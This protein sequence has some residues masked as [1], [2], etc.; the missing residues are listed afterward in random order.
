MSRSIA[1]CC[2]CST[3][4][5]T[6]PVH[7]RSGS[8]WPPCAEPPRSPSIATGS[9]FVVPARYRDAGGS[10]GA[11]GDGPAIRIRT[12][13][14]TSPSQPF[15]VPHPAITA[16]SLPRQP[17]QRTSSKSASRGSLRNSTSLMSR[18]ASAVGTFSLRRTAPHRSQPLAHVRD[19]SQ[20]ADVQLVSHPLQHVRPHCLK[21][22]SSNA[23]DPLQRT[24]ESEPQQRG[25][26]PSA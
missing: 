23:R 3:T 18:Q 12:A 24:L 19:P 15:H 25:L 8:L 7:Y 4:C 2:Q 16:C 22:C 6:A 20:L 9:A 14:A 26:R 13:L 21:Q 10:H 17:H 11:T 1:L 5:T